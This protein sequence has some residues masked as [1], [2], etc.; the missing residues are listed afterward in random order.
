[1]ELGIWLAGCLTGCVSVSLAKVVCNTKIKHEIPKRKQNFLSMLL[2]FANVA[3]SSCCYCWLS[4][5]L[6]FL[7]ASKTGKWSTHVL[8][9]ALKYNIE[10]IFA[11]TVGGKVLKSYLNMKF[12]LK[13]NRQTNQIT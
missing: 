5:L 6:V 2:F 9:I 4:L 7:F 10:V 1:M 12:L 13:T 8:F 3:G 11:R